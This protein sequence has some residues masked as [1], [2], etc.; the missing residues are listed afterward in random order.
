SAVLSTLFHF[1]PSI[2]LLRSPNQLSR[3][4]DLS[5][6]ARLAMARY[7][8]LIA[9]ALLVLSLVI[10]NVN[11]TL[12]VKRRLLPPKFLDKPGRLARIG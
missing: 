12:R 10:L 6:V 4:T 5:K 11:A 9:I 8:S 3:V 1:H 2:R 7:Y